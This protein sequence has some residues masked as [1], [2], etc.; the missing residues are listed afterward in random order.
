MSLPNPLHRPYPGD[1]YDG[2]TGE[3]TAW[4]RPDDSEPTGFSPAGDFLH[5]PQG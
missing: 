4:L 1:V 2:E 5:V 3:V